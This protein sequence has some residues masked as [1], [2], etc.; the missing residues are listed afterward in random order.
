MDWWLLVRTNYL[1]LG[2]T[3]VGLTWLAA[4]V[5]SLVIH[6]GLLRNLERVIDDIDG[7]STLRGRFVIL[8]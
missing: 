1:N 5:E 7:I 2:L 3:L 8:R 4:T 6:P